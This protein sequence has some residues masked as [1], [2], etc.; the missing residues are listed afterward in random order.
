[1]LNGTKIKICN[2]S[3]K[4]ASF[5]SSSV[6][7]QN[8]DELYF[9]LQRFCLHK[10]SL[11]NANFVT[12][13]EGLMWRVCVYS[14]TKIYIRE[15]LRIIHVDISYSQQ[16]SSSG[17]WYTLDDYDQLGLFWWTWILLKSFYLK[18]PCSCL[19][20]AAYIFQQEMLSSCL[21]IHLTEQKILFSALWHLNQIA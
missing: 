7:L 2:W 6:K 10:R 21:S 18:P 15:E 16:K 9:L 4:R 13:K 19:C 14:K 20:H 1:M 11:Q 12:Y 8:D 17:K 5:A 3:I